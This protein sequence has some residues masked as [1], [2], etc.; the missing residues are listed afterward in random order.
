MHKYLKKLVDER[1]ALSGLMQQVADK[2]VEDDRE[3]TDTEAQRMR[4]WQERAAV[5][6][7]A[8]SEQSEYLESQRSWASLQDKLTTQAD[9]ESGRTPALSTRAGEQPQNWGRAFTDSPQ[10]QRYDGTGGTGRVDVAGLFER[11]AIDTTFLPQP[12]S[13][14]IPQ[15]WTMTTPLLDAVG[16]ESV[17]SGTVEWVEYA[18][19]YPIAA[20]VPEGSLKPEANLVPTPH[21]QSLNTYAHYKG[22]TRQ[23]LEDIPR[24]QQIVEGAL[25]GG[26]LRKIE[27]DTAA[28]LVA[29]TL[30]A[31][32][33]ASLLEAIRVG[34]GTVQASG[35]SSPNAVLLNPADFADLDI[36][37]MGATVSGPVMGSSFWGV[38]AIAVGAV[39]AG[40]AYVGD[41]KTG[42]T[43]F[44]RGAA[45]V[46][47]TDSHADFF[48]RNTLVILAETRGLPV[49]T[50]P[51]SL[52]ECTVG[53]MAA[54]ASAN[55]G[56]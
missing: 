14:F 32:T 42:V 13:V 54:A 1:N 41:F 9:T 29:A 52:A 30:P 40:T 26:V 39:P 36:A 43:Y 22:I 6:D 5:L 37:V 27:D 2:A 28:A 4:D 33:G 47:M 38:R 48:L 56:K 18:G 24:I 8:C 53:V 50:Q 21:S 15:P 19:S 55:K 45:S 10:F 3:L 12:S 49:V 51:N 44:D 34:I 17:S 11:A 20:V 25:R 16:R 35:Y 46:Y 23:A 31:V 7:A